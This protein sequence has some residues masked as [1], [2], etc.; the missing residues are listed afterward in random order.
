MTLYVIPD[1]E[2]RPYHSIPSMLSATS[3]VGR[4]EILPLGSGFGLWLPYVEGF[5][6]YDTSEL[7]QSAANDWY[8]AK[9]AEGLKVA[10]VEE[11]K[12]AIDKG[13]KITWDTI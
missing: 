13:G 12:Q 8:K 2:W 4:F 9:M 10:T 1:L 3:V 11:L 6:E 7:A 5:R